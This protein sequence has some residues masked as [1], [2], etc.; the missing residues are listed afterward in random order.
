MQNTVVPKGMKPLSIQNLKHQDLLAFTCLTNTDKN[1]PFNRA[2]S[3]GEDASEKRRAITPAGR[4][5]K[6]RRVYLVTNT[7][8][9][10]N[11]TANET[12]SASQED[13]LL[14]TSAALSFDLNASTSTVTFQDTVSEDTKVGEATS[15]LVTVDNTDIDTPDRV[16]NSE[17]MDVSMIGIEE[18]TNTVTIPTSTPPVQTSKQKPEEGAQ[19]I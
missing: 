17:Q 1:I 5:E 12:L 10:A 16:A 14:N 15:L 11:T 8:P 19:S 7:P 3:D 13:A 18:T 9:P 6:K 4:E 2:N